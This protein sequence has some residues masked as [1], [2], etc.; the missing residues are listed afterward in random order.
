MKMVPLLNP[1]RK[2][3]ARKNS[4]IARKALPRADY[5]KRPSQMTG[6]K[7]TKRLLARRA[8]AKRKGTLPNPQ[9]YTREFI[10]KRAEYY[11]RE[12]G[13]DPSTVKVDYYA[14]GGGYTLVIV[15]HAKNGHYG[16]SRAPGFNETRHSAAVFVDML[17]CAADVAYWFKGGGR[18]TNPKK[19]NVSTL[20]AHHVLE[21]VDGGDSFKVGE[22]FKTQTSALNRAQELASR[23]KLP[24][25]V[26]SRAWI[27]KH[28][29]TG[30]GAW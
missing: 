14:A 18:A 19:S 28:L 9:R 5:I 27:K 30:F 4:T 12:L 17:G 26:A 16:E 11:A 29:A 1:I 2:R 6:T 24:H 13:I 21:P 15:D 20:E 23:T 22:G 7:P 10:D 8:V 25:R 3:K